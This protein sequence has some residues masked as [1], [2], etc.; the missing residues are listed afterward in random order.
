M[1]YIRLKGSKKELYINIKAIG[2]VIFIIG[3]IAAFLYLSNQDY[4]EATGKYLIK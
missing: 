4:L 1:I 3:Y 2:Q